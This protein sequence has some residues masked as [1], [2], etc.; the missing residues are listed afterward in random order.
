[1]LIVYKKNETSEKKGGII[2]PYILQFFATYN[3]EIFVL[4]S[5]NKTNISTAVKTKLLPNLL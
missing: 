4:F 3:F 1:M 5:K 2:L